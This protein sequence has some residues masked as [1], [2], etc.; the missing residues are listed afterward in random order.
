MSIVI[1][2]MYPPFILCFTRNVSLLEKVFMVH[3]RHMVC[4]SLGLQM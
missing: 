4:Q 1:E 2:R 3:E